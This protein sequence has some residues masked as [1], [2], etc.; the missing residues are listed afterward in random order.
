MQP[1]PVGIV[2]WVN[3][4]STVVVAIATLVLAVVTGVSLHRERKRDRRHREAVD[5]RIEAKAFELVG[6]LWHWNSLGWPTRA[7][8]RTK[9]DFAQEIRPRFAHAMSLARQ[10][11]EDAP[12]ASR[13]RAVVVRKVYAKLAATVGDLREIAKLKPGGPYRAHHQNLL[14]SFPV[15]KDHVESCNELLTEPAKRIAHHL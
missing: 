8:N 12:A 11:V 5:A 10:L 9:I 14:D 1:D 2:E 3:A 7:S 4:A 13:E 15:Y 6:E